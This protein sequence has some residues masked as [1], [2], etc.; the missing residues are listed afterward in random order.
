VDFDF[1]DLIDAHGRV[2]VEIVLLGAAAGDGDFVGHDV[3]EAFDGC[4]ADLIVGSAGIDDVAAD[5]AGDPDFVDFDGVG[6][7]E[8]EFDDFGEITTMRKLKGD[9]SAG[10]RGQRGGAPGGFFGD[11][12]EDAGH[13]RGIEVDRI[14]IRR[15]CGLCG[16]YL[17]GGK[18]FEAELHGIFPG[19]VGEFIEEGLKDPAE[20]V[21]AR[22][23]HGEGGNAER[24]K[25]GSKKKIGNEGGGKFVGGNIGG[26]REVLAFAKADEVI[27]PGDELAGRV[28]SAF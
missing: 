16:L 4:A 23:A 28:E 22:G 13:A 17:R 1:G 27:A 2:G 18:K 11:E 12:F 20:G 5:V 3:A 6:G 7:V 19:G 25:R 10:S 26:G 24:H 14:G 21:A 9:A 8:A 15:R